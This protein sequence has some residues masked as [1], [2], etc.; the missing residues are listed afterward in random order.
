MRLLTLPG[1]FR[2]RSDSWMLARWVGRRVQPGQSV[3][4]PFTGSGV[5]A[6]AAARAGATTTAIDI[7]R[8][9]VFCAWLNARLNGV[10]LE[11]VRATA[12]ERLDGRRFDLIAANPPYVPGA[13]AEPRG[14]ERAWEAGPDGRRFIDRICGEARERLAPGGRLLLI[15]SSI[16][17][18][19]ETLAALARGGLAGR[20][21]ERRLGQLGPLMSART[22]HLIQRGLLGADPVEELLVFEG[23]AG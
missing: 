4:D 14:A 12:P 3:L 19:E 15:H 6:V 1:V 9:A 18:E 13:V 21:V 22:E 5:V 16:C 10:W 11:V 17:G 23:L 20:V 8:R 2:P 7:S